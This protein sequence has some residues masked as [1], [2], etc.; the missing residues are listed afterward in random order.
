M[1]K[2]FTRID[3]KWLIILGVVALVN[4]AYFALTFFTSPLFENLVWL[5]RLIM[6]PAYPFL[7]FLNDGND[8]ASWFV[9]YVMLVMLVILPILW[10]LPVYGVYRLVSRK[11]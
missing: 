2:L 3:K 9:P 10:S 1:T 7:I 4:F 8:S 5:Q 11:Q 6:F